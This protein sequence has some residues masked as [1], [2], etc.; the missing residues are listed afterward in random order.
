MS[1]DERTFNDETRIAKRV[2]D[3]PS[4]DLLSLL[5]HCCL[6]SEIFSVS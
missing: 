1:N 2:N 3:L 4:F 5:R 6:P